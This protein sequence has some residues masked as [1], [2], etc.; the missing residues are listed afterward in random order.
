MINTVADILFR[1]QGLPWK[2]RSRRNKVTPGRMTGFSIRRAVA[3]DEA[4]IITLIVELAAYE[5]LGHL[6]SLT[7]ADVRRDFFG[8]AA[9][10]HCDLIFAGDEPAGLATWY[11]TYATF[12]ARRGL[13]VEDLYVRPPFRGRGY[14]KALLAHLARTAVA[15]GAQRLEWLVLDW[16]APS[17][18]FY[19]GIGGKRLE[20]WVGYRLEGAAMQKLSAL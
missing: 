8:A 19:D 17:I 14:G 18:A 10:V 9:A 2:I 3:G 16:N 11:W 6:L 4:L 20:G 1:C 12:R 15:E 5:K 7:E 13:Y